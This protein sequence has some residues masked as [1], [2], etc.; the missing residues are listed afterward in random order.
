[1]KPPFTYYGGKTT[2]AD[3]IVATL[4]DHD[5]YV[6]RMPAVTERLHRVSLDARPALDLIHAYGDKAGVLLYVDPPYL[7]TARG[8]AGSPRQYRHEMN[9]EDEHRELAKALHECRAA[10]VLS[11]YPSPLY[12]ELYADWHS[13]TLASATSQGGKWSERTEVLWSNRLPANDLFGG[14]M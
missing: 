1:M 14:A 13:T 7:G 3:R 11:G 9:R 12:D 6:D 10:V 8:E 4:P 5:H 2:L